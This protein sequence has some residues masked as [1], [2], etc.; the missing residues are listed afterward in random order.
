MNVVNRVWA[1][2]SVAALFGL[3]AAYAADSGTGKGS[4]TPLTYEGDWSLDCDK[5]S[6][7]GKPKKCK[8]KAEPGAG[9]N[10]AEITLIEAEGG[11]GLGPRCP[12]WVWKNGRWVQLC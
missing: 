10:G 4:V 8:V 7:N 12:T 11:E 6:P 2:L 9:P 3:S 1:C 5:D